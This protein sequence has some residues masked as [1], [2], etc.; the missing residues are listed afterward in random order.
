MQRTIDTVLIFLHAGMDD[1]GLHSFLGESANSML[2]IIFPT[3]DKKVLTYDQIKEVIVFEKSEGNEATIK[4]FFQY[5]CY[6]ANY[7]KG[8][9]LY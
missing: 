3:A 1:V 6:L 5:L 2:L 9:V 7:E 4:M 8:K